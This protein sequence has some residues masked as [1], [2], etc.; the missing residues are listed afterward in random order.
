MILESL[1]FIK[2]ELNLSR[3]QFNKS[4]TMKIVG[5]AIKIKSLIKN[6][7]CLEVLTVQFV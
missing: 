1:L 2:T 6:Y 5:F 3:E 4:I 7:L